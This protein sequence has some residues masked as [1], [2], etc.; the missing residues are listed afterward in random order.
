MPLVKAALDSKTTGNTGD[1][2]IPTEFDPAKIQSLS[3]KTAL[4]T[5]GNAGIGYHEVKYLAFSGAKVF[6]AARSEQRATDAID[7]ITAEATAAG[8]TVSI[9]FIRVDLAD[10]AQTKAAS[11]ALAAKLT[12]LDILIANAGIMDIASHSAFKLSKDGYEN[13]FATNHL[14]HFMLVTHLLPIILKTPGTPRIVNVSS[15]ATWRA[16]ETGIDYDSLQ[17]H[18]EGFTAFHYYGQSKLANVL[19]STELN[20][21]HGSKIIVNSVH[22][23]AV[24]TELIRPEPFTLIWLISFFV[25][26]GRLLYN[27]L[28]PEKGS[29]SALWAA[30]SP[31]IEAKGIKSKYIVPYGAVSDD[32][33]PLAMDTLHATKLWTYSETVCAKF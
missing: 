28:T 18:V 25:S 16:P 26:P 22:P 2:Y 3:G 19:F 29:Y 32:H 10:L 23:G 15:Y 30:T 12:R 14:G 7:R 1:K 8:K 31:E 33:H 21:R 5:G 20:A 24:D 4:V 27:L 11:V 9:E 17:K 13:M 6:L